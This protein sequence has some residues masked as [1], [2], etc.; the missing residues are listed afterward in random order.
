VLGCSL[1]VLHC[2]YP[3]GV[4]DV[5]ISGVGTGGLAVDPALGLGWV[6]SI[7]TATVRYGVEWCGDMLARW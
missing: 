1:Y 2:G 7:V 5:G 4:A 6:G 3:L